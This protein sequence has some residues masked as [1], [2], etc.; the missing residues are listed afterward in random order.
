MLQSF[1]TQ[2]QS[3]GASTSTVFLNDPKLYT[4]HPGGSM[5]YFGNSFKTDYGNSIT[6]SFKTKYHVEQGPSTTM[7]WRR[8]Y[9]DTGPWAGTTLSFSTNFYANFATATI[10]LTRTI[11]ASGNPYSGPQQTRIDF[12]ISAKSLSVET[13]FST[14]ETL[15]FV[16]I[17]G[18]TIESRFLRN[19]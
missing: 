4:S 11:Y 5:G 10:S 17:Y 15:P 18:Y 12:G 14:G 3:A 1:T 19:V 13:R 7:E 6:L 8:F 2:V 9:L 16:R